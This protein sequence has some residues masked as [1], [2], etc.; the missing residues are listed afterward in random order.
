VRWS[1][2]M[3]PQGPGSSFWTGA[4]RIR[5]EHAPRSMARKC[6][7]YPIRGANLGNQHSA[8]IELNWGPGTHAPRC[9]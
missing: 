2:H 3:K 9:T 5:T 6:D 4:V 1:R 7:R 8:P